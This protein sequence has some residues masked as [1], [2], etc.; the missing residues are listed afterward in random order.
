MILKNVTVQDFR[1]IAFASLDFSGRR[2]F[3]VGSN[4]Q[5]KTNLLEAVG[6]VT[7]LRSFRSADHRLLIR[8][9][10]KEAGVRFVFDHDLMDETPVRI[11]IRP[12]GRQVTVDQEKVSRLADIIGKFPTVV[13]SSDDV[14]FVRASPG[15]RRRWMDLVLA[16]ADPAYLQ[17][18]Q[19]YHRGL[20][21]R[22]RLLKEQ[23]ADREIASFEMVM[24]AAAVAVFRK[25]REALERLGEFVS[26]YYRVISF[27]EEEAA[28]D[29]RPDL[30]IESDELIL[31]QWRKSRARDRLWG[32]TQRGPHRDDYLLKLD[33]HPAREY[34]SEGQQRGL[35]LALRF[36]QVQYFRE[37]LRI[38]PVVLADDI[39]NELDP[40]RRAQFWE[41]L[42]E[43][44]QVIATG[45]SLPPGGAWQVFRVDEGVFES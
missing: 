11:L 40:R 33:G 27:G 42:G 12:K 31:E 28:F 17:V 16:A 41:M 7:A 20:A 24:A 18:L 23:A 15:T 5:G 3:F 1:N 19:E 25:R 32:A 21:A 35:V 39:V 34:A 26:D 6:Y 4:G 14:Q 2:Q 13:F 30:R 10:E 8:H 9:G 45:T 37:M 36:A 44:V 38:L 43:E 29:F 22:N